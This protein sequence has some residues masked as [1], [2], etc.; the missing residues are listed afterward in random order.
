ME[1][2]FNARKHR[3][4]QKQKDAN[5]KQ[6][7][8]DMANQYDSGYGNSTSFNSFGGISDYRRKKV[9]YDLFNSI[10]DMRDFSYV[11]QP[12]GAEVGDLPATMTNR[13][14]VSGKIKVMMGM[15]MSMPFAWRVYAVNEE[16]TTRRE[17]EEFGRIRDYVVNEI[18]RPIKQELE[19]KAAQEA[20]GKELTQQQQQEIQQK[21]AQETEAQTPDE[22][23]KYMVR[24]HQDPAEVQMNQILKYLLQFRKIEG[25]FNKGM[26]HLCLSGEDVFYVGIVNGEPDMWPVNPL[27]FEYDMSPDQDFIHKGEW[28]KCEYQMTPSEFVSNFGSELSNEQIDRVY[29]YNHNPASIRDEDF[30]FDDR[31]N[32]GY[33]IRVVHFTFKSLRKIG[34]LDFMSPITGDIES[35]LVDENY[36][37]NLELGDVKIEWE[38]IP[39]AHEVWKALDD[40]YV[41]ARPVPGQ[42]KDMDNLYD[43]NLPYYGMAVDNLN[44]PVTSPMDRIKSYQYFYDVLI[45]R[46]ELLMASDKGK[47]L[48]MNINS[49]PKSSGIDTAQFMYFMEANHIAFLNPNE[50]GNRAGGDITNMVKEI[51][52]SL[53][54]QIQD[55]IQLAEYIERKCGASIGVTPQMEAQIAA[56]EAVSNTRQN[57]VQSSYI[58]KPYFEIHNTVKTEALNALLE[59]AKVAY[60]I[61][62]P[63]KLSYVLDDMSVF[64]FTVD[65]GMLDNSTFGLFVANS[66]KAD[67]AK[68]M[69]ETLAQAALQNQQA[70]LSDIIKVMRADSVVEAEEMLEVA[71]QRKARELNAMDQQKLAAQQRI[72]EMEDAQLD[73]K[74]AHE[75]KLVV[76]K[77]GER[78]KTELQ[79]QA[80]LSIGFNEDKDADDDGQLDVLEVYKAGQKAQIDARRMELDEAK[81]EHQKGVDEEKLENDK[82]KIKVS[83]IKGGA[84]KTK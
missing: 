15:E 84:A 49:I 75:E 67:D 37:F 51:D 81:F 42:Y 47:I 74:Y 20:Q 33:T 29:D 16:A 38:W 71:N 76:L 60:S 39:E 44:S 48:A 10:I 54:K 34:F 43:C 80:M 79:K 32:H 53:V 64:M 6:W 14:I 70:D 66:G 72:A 3:L 59:T 65:Q 24:E 82:E 18:M 63:R 40:I 9:N 12:Y 46:I 77:E 2:T 61:G 11:C 17:Q 78:R 31:E 35:R 62:K 4:T 73:K 26:K 83:R 50:E 19:L 57:L 55:Y 7:Y 28:A 1:Y 41:Y 69:V 23:R 25:K 5:D 30:T 45:Y 21:I 58:M 27:F 52:M 8:K 22:V 13:D 68:K 36:K 56:N